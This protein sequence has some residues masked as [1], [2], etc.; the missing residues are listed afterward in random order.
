MLATDLPISASPLAMLGLGT[1]SKI[2]HFKEQHR[3]Y[4]CRGKNQL[5]VSQIKLYDNIKL[6]SQCH[7]LVL[8]LLLLLLLLKALRINLLLVDGT[9]GNTLVKI[10]PV[11][12]VQ[13]S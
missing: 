7:T 12:G 6:R 3:N 2:Y 5:S 11:K 4:Y 9:V 10:P 13:G 1:G 8:L